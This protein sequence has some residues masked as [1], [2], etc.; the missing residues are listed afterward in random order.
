M[1]V[2]KHDIEIAVIKE[3]MKG[4]KRAL[5]LQHKLDSIHFTVLNNENGR[6]K[7]AQSMF[8]G[9][10]IHDRDISEIKTMR[11][12][13]MNELRTMM[14]PLA[15]YVLAQQGKGDLKQWIP[16]LIAA[17]TLVWSVLKK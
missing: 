5:E 16:W 15:E 7:E 17:A 11:D 6:V 10:E 8:V 1:S 13:D 12:R 4:N 2:D 9:K 3:R 14:K